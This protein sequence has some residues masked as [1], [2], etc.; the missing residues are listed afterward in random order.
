MSSSSTAALVQCN[1]PNNKDEVNEID[2]MLKH[3]YDKL[4][5]IDPS[6]SN[7]FISYTEIYDLL[8]VLHD[9]LTCN[10]VLKRDKY[11]SDYSD[12]LKA[13][14]ECIK[15]YSLRRDSFLFIKL[16]GKGAFGEVHLVKPK[17]TTPNT[18]SSSSSNTILFAMKVLSK[19]EML[20]RAESA[21]FK[22]ERDLL[23]TSALQ[24]CPWIV[25]LHYAFQDENYLY[26]LMEYCPGGNLLNLLKNS[27]R[28]NFFIYLFILCVHS[29]I[30]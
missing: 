18:D 22:A 7:Q 1:Q 8:I 12:R 25:N 20:K 30:K 27:E 2:S 4:G 6:D 24:K 16:L 28:V 14:I 13:K 15:K 9:E 21:C 10:P 17:E 19:W 11:L 23:V 3:L 26:I 29:F 5:V